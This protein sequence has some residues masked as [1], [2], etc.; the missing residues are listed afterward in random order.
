MT[1]SQQS[2]LSKLLLPV[3]V[4]LA[5]ISQLILFFTK[6]NVALALVGPALLL[7]LFAARFVTDKRQALI[8]FIFLFFVIDDVVGMPWGAATTVTELLGTVLFGIGMPKLHELFAFFLLAWALVTTPRITL[9]YLCSKGLMATAFITGLLLVGAAFGTVVGF[10]EG[11]NLHSVFVQIRFWPMIFVWS[12]IGFIMIENARIAYAVLKALAYAMIFKGV[13]G[14]FNYLVHIDLFT[15]RTSQ[16]LID[17]WTS[18]FFVVAFAFFIYGLVAF[19]N[20]VG[21]ILFILMALIPSVIS[22]AINDRRAS[23]IAAVFAVGTLPMC[24]PFFVLYRKRR[25]I[26]K[27]T[28]AAVSFVILTWPLPPPIGFVGSTVRSFTE[29]KTEMPDSRGKENYNIFLNLF[30]HPVRGIGLGKELKQLTPM[31]DVS[32]FYKNIHLLPHN[33]L[34]AFWAFTGALGMAAVSTFFAMFFGVMGRLIMARQKQIAVFAV[35]GF[36][37]AWQ[38]LVFANADLGLGNSKLAVL[39]GLMFGG[40]L[41]LNMM[42][43]H[44]QSLTP[45]SGAISGETICNQRASHR[46]GDTLAAAQKENPVY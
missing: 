32:M 44:N 37:L 18:A 40:G 42:L 2:L 28:L 33:S 1:T 29:K 16:Y 23:L 13:Q 17:H 36:C 9:F 12:L 21:K 22:Y 39:G 43:R 19:K 20:H 5:V 7:A 41:R 10:N 6:G 15:H 14:V 27:L 11:G 35:A 8:L 38:Y 25:L 31:D 3:T 26:I 45:T 30:K 4:I 34:F 24:L 46:E